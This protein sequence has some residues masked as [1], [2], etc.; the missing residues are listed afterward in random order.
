MSF[1][2]VESQELPRGCGYRKPGGFYLVSDGQGDPCG[3]LPIPLKRCPCCG[4]GVKFSR[5]TTWLDP[6]P[7]SKFPCAFETCRTDCTMRDPELYGRRVM[8]KCSTDKQV[9]A[10]LKDFR[11]N[12]RFEN[13]RVV[14]EGK[15]RVVEAHFPHVLLLWVGEKFYPTTE[16]Y[17]QEA[18]RLGIS[19]RINS[20]P[21]NFEPG[22][23]WVW[24]AHI[25][26]IRNPK[27]HPDGEFTPGVFHIFQ[28][29]QV[30]YVVAEDDDD[31][32]LEA[33]SNK[34]YRLVKVERVGEQLEI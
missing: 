7:F 22:S 10:A 24:L 20:V 8:E 13:V 28:P 34:G 16:A 5:G 1:Q 9:E 25:N 21:R 18:D 31:D 27:N 33:L 6:R 29:K 32:R 12:F 14:G 26:A 17:L 3:R 19:R 4:E 30:D 2:I 15:N 11:S 23:T